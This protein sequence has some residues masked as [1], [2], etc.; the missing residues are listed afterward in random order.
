M[1]EPT[2]G[3]HAQP[4]GAAVR[5]GQERFVAPLEETPLAAVDA[6]DESAPSG[7]LFTEAWR[8]LRTRP[9][10]IIPSVIIIALVVVSLFPSWFTSTDPR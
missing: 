10:F 7:G 5:P 1:S 9:L 6:V 2:T 8:Q 3:R 4:G